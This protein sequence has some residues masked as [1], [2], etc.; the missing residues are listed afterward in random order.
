MN[1]LSFQRIPKTGEKVPSKGYYREKGELACSGSYYYVM[2]EVKPNP[3]DLHWYLWIIYLL[4]NNLSIYLLYLP[5][6]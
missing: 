1:V 3:A 6:Y 4:S 2:V 5:Y